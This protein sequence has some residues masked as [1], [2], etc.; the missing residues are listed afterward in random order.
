MDG[1]GYIYIYIVVVYLG[2]L[3]RVKFGQDFDSDQSTVD[4]RHTYQ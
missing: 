1:L 3:R 4:S 2:P